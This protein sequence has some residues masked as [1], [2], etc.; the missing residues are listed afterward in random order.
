METRKPNTD[1]NRP[2]ETRVGESQSKL[3]VR[4]MLDEKVQDLRGEIL[5]TVENLVVN[6]ATNAV[7]EVII[8]V[9]AFLG[10][11]GKL[12][13]FPFRE[14]KYDPARKAFVLDRDKQH[15]EGGIEKGAWPEENVHNYFKK[16][17]SKV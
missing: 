7:E 3:T 14:L 12:F 5:G 6:P 4:E 2:G 16:V 13:R 10:M 15:L 11:G 8:Q 9:G 17:I 1:N